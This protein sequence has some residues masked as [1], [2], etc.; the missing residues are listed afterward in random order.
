MRAYISNKPVILKLSLLLFFCVILIAETKKVSSGSPYQSPG[1]KV[2]TILT[3]LS[4]PWE[5]VFL[6]DSSMLFTE[7]PGRVRLYKKGALKTSPVFQLTDIDTTKKMGL[8]G[9]TLHPEFKTNRYLYLAS[10]YRSGERS[11]LRVVRYL[12]QQDT[13]TQPKTIIESIPANLNHTGCRLKFGPDGKLYISC[14]DADEAAKA[15]NPGALNGKILRLNDD[16]SIPAD[17]P[18]VHQG[19]ARAEVWSYGHRN[20][21]GIAFQPGSGKMYVSEHG[22]NGGDEVNIVQKGGNYGW[23]VVH[24]Q[25]TNDS[26]ISPLL[27]FT[28]SIAP[29]EAIFYN[30]NA[31]PQLKGHLLIACLRGE[32][33][34]NIQ[35]NDQGVVTH[36]FLL[37]KQLGRIRAL[38]V[39]PDGYIYLST[40]QKDPPEGIPGPDDD[41]I[42]RLIPSNSKAVNST[43]VA[44]KPLKKSTGKTAMPANPTEKLFTELCINCHGPT[45]KGTQWAKAINNESWQHGGSMQEVISS[46]RNGYPQKGMPSWQGAIAEKDIKRLGT[47]FMQMAKKNGKT[48]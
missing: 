39:G 19:G 6:P 33:I 18:F 47:Y 4:V 22:P 1:F 12:F 35:L 9:L 23:P 34:L 16:G 32:A 7:R 3:N 14:G 15:Q 17:N 27:E 28:P 20:A 43:V 42:L 45:L 26:M 46:I 31:I 24:H 25:L 36:D 10:N 41:K 48:R 38:A 29:A 11:F 40:S 37:Q 5:I 8:L 2:E 30:N 21:Q 44:N 13:L